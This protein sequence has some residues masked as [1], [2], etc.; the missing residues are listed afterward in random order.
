[1]PTK[2]INAGK[3][4]HILEALHKGWFVLASEEDDENK[5]PNSYG[6]DNLQSQD[7]NDEEEEDKDVFDHFGL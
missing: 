1:M 6:C 4:L 2:N 5:I 7:I 3:V